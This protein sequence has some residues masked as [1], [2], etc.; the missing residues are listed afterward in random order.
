LT[1]S[2]AALSP[3]AFADELPSPVTALDAGR[4]TKSSFVP[5]LSFEVGSGW[6]STQSTRGFFD[7]QDDPGSLDVIA[8]Q[9]ANIPSFETA[10]AAAASVEARA[11]VVVNAREEVEVAGLP[12]IQLEVDTTDPADTE[13]PIFRDVINAAPGPLAIAP[14]RRLQLNLVDTPDG[15][16]AVLVGGSVANWE[17]TLEM[18]QPVLDSLVVDAGRFSAGYSRAYSSLAS[19]RPRRESLTA[20]AAGVSRRP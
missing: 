18:A 11:N 5:A 17:T 10:E 20:S 13:P 15:V 8:V 3:T 4:Y 7:I 2:E 12:A 6:S 14:G 19:N 1:P 9:F 16:L